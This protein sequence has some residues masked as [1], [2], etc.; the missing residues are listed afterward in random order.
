MVV[1]VAGL[2]AFI[3]IFNWAAIAVNARNRRRGVT[4]HVSMVFAV[5]QMLA[6]LAAVFLSAA[7]A[8]WP[9]LRTVWGIALA[10]CSFWFLTRVDLSY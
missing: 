8:K 9:S 7:H 1:I 4:R 5:A 3:V 10:D 2:A 6:V